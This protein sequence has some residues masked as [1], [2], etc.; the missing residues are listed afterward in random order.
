LR[1]Q[2]GT[3]KFAFFI[4]M[5]W[6]NDVYYYS[7][8]ILKAIARHYSSL[9]EDGL[10][11]ANHHINYLHSVAEY[12][13]DFDMALNAIGRGKWNGSLHPNFGHYRYYG[14]LQQ[15]IIADILG[16]LDYHLTGLGFYDIPKLRGM[17]YF[18]MTEFLNERK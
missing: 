1:L 4:A 16:L 12:K 2:N 11:I 14:R 15:I 6:I 8:S 10:L 9:Y 3:S 18:R 5:V 17:A 13:A 7:K